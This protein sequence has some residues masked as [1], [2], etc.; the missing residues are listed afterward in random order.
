MKILIAAVL[1]SAIM[2]VCGGSYGFPNDTAL[3]Q[4][5]PA[6]NTL[7]VQFP[8][9]A[10]LRGHFKLKKELPAGVYLA[11]LKYRTPGVEKVQMDCYVFND[12]QT[13]KNAGLIR[14]RASSEWE[15]TAG[16]I[17]LTRPGMPRFSFICNKTR[18]I[19]A[20]F[21]KQKG[22]LEIRELEIT[23]LESDPLIANGDFKYGIS[24][25]SGWMP[26]PGGL[27][28]PVRVPGDNGSSVMR[29]ENR[30][31]KVQHVYSSSFPLEQKRYRVSFEARA[32]GGNST[33]TLRIVDWNWK[34][35]GGKIS[36]TLGP[37]WKKYSAEFD[38]SKAGSAFADFWCG[39]GTGEIRNFRIDLQIQTNSGKKQK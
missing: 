9:I 20:E 35:T 6:G 24:M 39:P 3:Y 29:V 16:I 31:D 18:I 37:D 15:E 2:T 21:Y 5:K 26:S 34:W 11:S 7:T 25:P 28:V 17:R 27:V 22:S 12:A 1:F 38:V 30:T 33:L 23:R 10:G 13:P 4:F 14:F 32:Q 8:E 19:P 36:R